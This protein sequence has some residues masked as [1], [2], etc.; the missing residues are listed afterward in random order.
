MNER[1]DVVVTD[2]QM[3]FGSMVV[4]MVKWAIAS[5]PALIILVVLGAL[6]GGFLGATIGLFG[7]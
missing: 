1:S 3:A 6:V 7:F 2:I 5:I 4:F